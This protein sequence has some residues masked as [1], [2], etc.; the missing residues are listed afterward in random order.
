MSSPTV[1]IYDPN[2]KVTLY[3]TIS[4]A[5]L[6]G[7]NPASQRFQGTQRTID[8]TPFFGEGGS[9]R[10]SKSVRDPA[11]GFALTF[12]DQPFIGEY[13]GK[14][15]FESLYGLVEPMDYI[16][17][18]FRHNPSASAGAQPPI[19]MRGFVSAVNRVEAMGSD[20]KPQRAVTVTGQD[21]GKIWQMMQILYLPGFVVGEDILSNFKLFERF[22][23]VVDVLP[24]A[25]FVAQIF[26]QVI[27]PFLA[28]LA[29]PNSIV[30]SAIEAFQYLAVAH[31]VCSFQGAQNQEGSIYNILKTYGDVGTWNELYLQD[32]EDGV[33]CVYRPIPTM[34]LN[35]DLIQQDAPSPQYVD[36][37][38]VDVVSLN[39]SRTD[40]SVANYYW[41][42]APRFDL[43]DSIYS[44]QFAL[45][46]SDPESVLQTTYPNTLVSLYGLR[47]ML[48]DSQMG[49]DEVTSMGGGQLAPQQNV[50]N[51]D[52]CDW[53]NDRRQIM[54]AQNQDNILYESGS[55][56]V[57]GNEG[58]RAGMYVRLHRGTFVA[59]YYVVSVAHDYMP[60]Q[61]VFSTLTLERGTGFIERVK[62]GGGADSPYLAEMMPTPKDL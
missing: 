35:G 16:E 27:N 5:T 26:K 22:G 14:Q 52:M 4:R 3:K 19:I 40:A 61:G 2:L 36:I 8:L 33:H 17:I 9:V 41:V 28:T 21:F 42:R 37:S 58:V 38:D 6:N 20:G 59:T 50:R 55:M 30:P 10:T 32:E 53:I 60:F 39:V 46:G 18:R 23:G 49:G 48:M 51:A 29:P 43:V 15:T 1:K 47:P 45:Q 24:A 13:A 44:Q 7:S 31:G 62:R 12:G 25:Q 57:R 11:G 56:R 54:A 34:D